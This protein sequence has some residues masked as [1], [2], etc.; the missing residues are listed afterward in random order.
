MYNRLL[1]LYKDGLL[2]EEG[3][4]NAVKKDLIKEDQKQQIIRSL[5][6]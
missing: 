1:T 3:L 4:T 2:S 5:I 6:A